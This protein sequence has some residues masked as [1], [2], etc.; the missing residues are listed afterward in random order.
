MPKKTRKELV[1]QFIKTI[2]KKFEDCPLKDRKKLFKELEQ[3][4][5]SE[6]NQECCEIFIEA[7]YKAKATQEA[8]MEIGIEKA[9]KKIKAK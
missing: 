3:W 4:A 1:N 7:L 9:L 5:Y 8:Q 6:L 2:N